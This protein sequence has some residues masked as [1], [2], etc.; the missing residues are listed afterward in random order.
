[1]EQPIMVLQ[2]HAD[3]TTH[4]IIIPKAIAEQWGYDYYMEIYADRIVL[5]PIKKGE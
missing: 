4:K 3:V 5:K 2:K 1:M